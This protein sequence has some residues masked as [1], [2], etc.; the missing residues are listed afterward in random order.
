M[1]KWKSHRHYDGDGLSQCK[2]DPKASEAFRRKA[3]QVGKMI[4]E[5]GDQMEHKD[6]LEYLAEKYDIKTGIDADGQKR[7]L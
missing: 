2:T 1:E 6:L 5:Q 3:C 4:R 7:S